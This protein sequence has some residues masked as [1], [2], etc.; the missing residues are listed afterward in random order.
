MLGRSTRWHSCTCG[1][2]EF[3]AEQTRGTADAALA[4]AHFTGKGLLSALQR[5]THA[6]QDIKL[7]CLYIFNRFLLLDLSH[8]KN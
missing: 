4:A 3:P 5:L 6:P 7:L 8:C 1:L 2:P